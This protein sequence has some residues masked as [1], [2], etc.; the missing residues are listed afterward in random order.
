MHHSYFTHTLHTPHNT[1][2]PPAIAVGMRDTDTLSKY[3]ALRDTHTCT[4]MSRSITSYATASNEILTKPAQ[5]KQNAIPHIK[6]NH[7]RK[8]PILATRKPPLSQEDTMTD[9]AHPHPS[10]LAQV[11][12]QPALC[13]KKMHSQNDHLTDQHYYTHC[14]HQ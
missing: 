9:T 3:A 1:H 14:H 10:P 6:D 4:I 2:T 8:H 12:P 11:H 5:A 13:L 7:L